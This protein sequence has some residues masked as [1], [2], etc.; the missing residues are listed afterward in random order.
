M[1]APNYRYN[2]SPLLN[3][4]RAVFRVLFS[5]NFILIEVK[6]KTVDGR[7]ARDTRVLSRTD[8]DTES[9][10]L[11]LSAAYMHIEKQL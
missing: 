1:K 11:T 10:L 6:E 7:P 5:R 8:Y 9:D 2:A 4:L 3:R